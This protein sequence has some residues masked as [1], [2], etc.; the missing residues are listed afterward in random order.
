[1]GRRE[2]LEQNGKLIYCR[3]PHEL[4]NYA[5]RPKKLFNF[6]LKF[7]RNLPKKNKERKLR[8][9]TRDIC[10][11]LLCTC[12]LLMEFLVL[13]RR[14]VLTWLIKIFMRPMLKVHAD[15]RFPTPDLE[16]GALQIRSKLTK[17]KKTIAHRRNSGCHGLWTGAQRAS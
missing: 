3:G 13:T 17:T 7:C 11:D 9:R 2:H 6:I 15:R 5:D 1:M 16:V 10:C 14:C 4:S 12:L 8:Q